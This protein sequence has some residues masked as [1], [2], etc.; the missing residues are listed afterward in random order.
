M[1]WNVNIMAES[2]GM[3]E[4]MSNTSQITIVMNVITQY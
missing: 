1:T 2:G 3:Y 4:I